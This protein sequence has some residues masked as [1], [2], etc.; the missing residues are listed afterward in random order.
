MVLYTFMVCK[1][2]G[3]LHVCGYIARV[4]RGR[5]SLAR[6]FSTNWG[7]TRPF[8]FV[9]CSAD[10]GA[11]III[12]DF[13]CSVR[14]FSLS[15]LTPQRVCDTLHPGGALVFS[16]LGKTASAIVSNYIKHRKKI[17]HSMPCRCSVYSSLFISFSVSPVLFPIV[18]STPISAN[19]TST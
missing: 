9:V 12:C 13:L 2:V 16:S 4:W 18:T 15:H 19:A 5:N 6:E 7:A 11:P 17:K 3:I 14:D 8:V 10:E 1:C